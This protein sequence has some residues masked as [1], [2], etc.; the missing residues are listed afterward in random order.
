MW[1]PTR[2][3]RQPTR[4]HSRA[5][6]LTRLSGYDSIT[7]D[8]RPPQHEG[9]KDGGKRVLSVPSR[10]PPGVIRPPSSLLAAALSA[11][12]RVIFVSFIRCPDPSARCAGWV[13]PGWHNVEGAQANLRAWMRRNTQVRLRVAASNKLPARPASSSQLPTTSGQ[14]R[15][16]RFPIPD[17]LPL[18]IGAKNEDGSR[19][20]CSGSSDSIGSPAPQSRWSIYLSI[21]YLSIN[22]VGIVYYLLLD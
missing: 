19:V 3:G 13:L 9:W 2:E 6:E 17:S 7:D 4:S 5:V 8:G 10:R 20:H 12:P 16:E 22:Q 21:I 11:L 14:M 18:A 1:D 15:W